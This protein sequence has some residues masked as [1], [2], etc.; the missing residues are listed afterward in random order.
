[1]NEAPASAS[2]AAQ[3]NGWYSPQDKERTKLGTYACLASVCA[4]G[5]LLGVRSSFV[6]V[7]TRATPVDKSNHF[8]FR[9][10]KVRRAMMEETPRVQL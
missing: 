6:Y 4:N 1:M 10:A 9:R 3:P 7:S 2:F 8:F 5:R